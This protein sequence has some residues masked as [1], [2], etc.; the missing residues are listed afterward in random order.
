[1]NFHRPFCV[2]KFTCLWTNLT[3]MVK[4]F[5]YSFSFSYHRISIWW[6]HL[7]ISSQLISSKIQTFTFSN[8]IKLLSSFKTNLLQYAI[9]H[10]IA[11]HD[12][13]FFDTLI[14]LDQVLKLWDMNFHR[15]F[16]VGKFTYLWRN[17]TANG[18]LILH[19][20]APFKW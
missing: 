20:N 9:S 1:M 2:G 19:V 7:F 17:L 18:R 4:F 12:I 16:C 15:P 11:F 5:V 8:V 3:K 13:I 10:W 6:W 14:F